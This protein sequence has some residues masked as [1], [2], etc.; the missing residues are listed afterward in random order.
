MVR[1]E[2]TLRVKQHK[3]SHLPVKGTEKN[4]AAHKSKFKYS[5]MTKELSLVSSCDWQLF[6]KIGD[7]HCG[8]IS[9][10]GVKLF[11]WQ[12]SLTPSLAIVLLLPLSL[13]ELWLI[14][15]VSP[16]SLF[17]TWH[18][19]KEST[20]RKQIG[21][22]MKKLNLGK[23]WEA[24]FS[25]NAGNTF[26]AST[27]TA[28][29]TSQGSILSHST[30]VLIVK[31]ELLIPPR[32]LPG[33]LQSNS[34]GWGWQADSSTSTS[35][36]TLGSTVQLSAPTTDSKTYTAQG[37]LFY[38]F[39]CQHCFSV[40]PSLQIPHGPLLSLDSASDSSS[41]CMVYYCL[42]PIPT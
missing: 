9:P 2:Y 20:G 5:G 36:Q 7:F 19:E 37:I 11:P 23:C 26:L 21:I 27:D 32:S 3:H 24:G 15:L 12:S 28:L 34:R 33:H 39:S 18:M 38:H 35:L 42:Y 40:I 41:L 16:L 29:Y 4:A 6:L 30:Y 14:S 8:L 22:C 31:E 17:C 1:G 25:R 10:A 13:S